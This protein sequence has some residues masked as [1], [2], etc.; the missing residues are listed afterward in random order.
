VPRSLAWGAIRAYYSAFF[1]AHAIMRLFGAACVQLDREYT[2]QLFSVAVMLGKAGSITSLDSGYFST[3]IDSN[4]DS[5]SFRRVRDPHRDTWAA[6][7]SVLGNIEGNVRDATAIS[8]HK[9]EAQAL[10]D[11][12]RAQLTR[13][14]HVKGNWLSWCR[15]SINYRQ[16]HG[17]WFPYSRAADPALVEAAGRA[18]RVA[19]SPQG[20]MQTDGD[21][22]SFFGS[23]AGLVGF[24]RELTSAAAKLNS[25][26]NPAIT[27][28]CVRL[29]NQI[30]SASPV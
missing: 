24:L 8:A 27:N 29:L 15:N 14:N 18:W 2:N 20:A 10:I 12:I 16:S 19:Q 9:V 1:A 26:T 25:P 17:V 5:I 7:L 6:F 23:A 30:V 11:K 28:G 13:A 21:L 4:Y 3:T 22:S